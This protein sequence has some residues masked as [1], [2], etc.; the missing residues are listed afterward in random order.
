MG[1]GIRPTCGDPQS[2][3]ERDLDRPEHA[4]DCCQTSEETTR[5]ES[6]SLLILTRQF[7]LLAELSSQDFTTPCLDWDS[8]CD[9]RFH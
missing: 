6:N 2:S 3:V 9:Q 8:E 1:S 7:S 5:T 4:V